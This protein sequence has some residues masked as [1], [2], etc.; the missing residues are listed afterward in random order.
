MMYKYMKTANT[1]HHLFWASI[2]R[3]ERC[4]DESGML[5]CVRERALPGFVSI[6]LSLVAWTV[7]DTLHFKLLLDVIGDTALYGDR[8]HPTHVF[9]WPRVST[10]TSRKKKEGGEEAQ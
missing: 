1:Q 8:I 2:G 6:D 9:I 3:K 5:E 7:L 10:S 4:S